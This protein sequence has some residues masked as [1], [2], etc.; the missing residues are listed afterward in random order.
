MLQLATA[1][2]FIKFDNFYILSVYIFVKIKK[3]SIVNTTSRFSLASEM[4]YCYDNWKFESQI[5][6]QTTSSY[7]QSGEAWSVGVGYRFQTIITIKSSNII[8]P[9]EWRVQ[10]ALRVLKQIELYVYLAPNLTVA[11]GLDYLS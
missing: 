4:V 3:N 8:G 6:F 9:T 1:R 2:C 11:C 7:W 5:S 10:F